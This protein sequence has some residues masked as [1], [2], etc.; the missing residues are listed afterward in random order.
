[1]GEVVFEEVRGELTPAPAPASPAQEA[2]EAPG[3][4]QWQ[5]LQEALAREDW[6]RQRLAAD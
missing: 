1:M 4:E 3:E 5:R 2:D 6:R